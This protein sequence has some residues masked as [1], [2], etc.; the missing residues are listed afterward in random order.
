MIEDLKDM[1][2]EEFQ[3]QM[4]ELIGSGEDA[5]SH[6]HVQNCELAGALL[7]DLET[8]AEAAGSYSPSWTRPTACGSSIESAINEEE[9]KSSR[10]RLL[11]TRARHHFP[12][13]KAYAMPLDPRSK[14]SSYPSSAT[15]T[16]HE[17]WPITF[18]EQSYVRA[19]QDP[20]DAK[21]RPSR[22][23]RVRAARTPTAGK[24]PGEP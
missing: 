2:C 11:S 21:A 23:R 20:E 14:P 3:A 17:P 8:I 19:L 6:P 4:A 13:R 10:Q 1:T 15:L 16:V 22:S 18:R 7:A 24:R 12:D 5:S 9:G